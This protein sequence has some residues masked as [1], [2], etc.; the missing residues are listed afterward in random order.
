MPWKKVP[1]SGDRYGL[2]LKPV[3]EYTTFRFLSCNLNPY[4]L[5]EDISGVGFRIADEIA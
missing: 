1:P 4:R 3:G 2:L 5:A